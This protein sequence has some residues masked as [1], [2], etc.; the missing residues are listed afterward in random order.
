MTRPTLVLRKL[1]RQPLTFGHAAVLLLV[2]ALIGGGAFAVAAIPGP[3]GQITGCIKKFAPRKGAVRVID[4]NSRCARGERTVSWNQEG[5]PGV[6]GVA[7]ER[8]PQGA[9]G[10]QGQ[11]GTQGPAGSPDTPAQ[12]LAKLTQV[13]GTSSGL[14]ADQLDG[15]SSDAFLAADRVRLGDPVTHNDAT[16]DTILSTGS[17]EFRDDGTVDADHQVLVE[18]NTTFGTDITVVPR[19]GAQQTGG[20]TALP[21]TTTDNILDIYVLDQFG[22][23]HYVRCAFFQVATAERVTCFEVNSPD[24]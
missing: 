18:K 20:V 24:F 1:L 7:G 11:Q 10:Q 12:V 8:G 21:V 5:P 3:D 9:A 13:D 6:A 19:T 16:G 17:L 14:D 23:D 4:S 15:E 22:D 2:T